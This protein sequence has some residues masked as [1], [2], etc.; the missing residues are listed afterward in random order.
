MIGRI[1]GTVT[2]NRWRQNPAPSIWAASWMSWGIEVSPAIKITVAS[3]RMR[4]TWMT[5]TEAMARC[6]TPSHINHPS[7]VMSPSASRVQLMTL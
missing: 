3:G 7:F 4:Q 1:S 6:G 2:W 5:M